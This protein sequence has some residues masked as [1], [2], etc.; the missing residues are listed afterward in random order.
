MKKF[1]KWSGLAILAL[2]AVLA[3]VIAI[4]VAPTIE[5]IQPR[6]TTQYWQMESGY[7]LAYTHVPAAGVERSN[8]PIIFLHGGPGGYIHSSYIERA[9]T[10]AAEG[11]DV[12]LYDQIGSGLSDRLPRPKDYSF[13]GHAR[14]LDEIISRHLSADNA[15]LIGQSYG[16]MLVSYYTAMHPDRVH[17][18]IL[19]S[20]GDI[21]PG[22]FDEAGNW[23]NAELYPVPDGIEFRAPLDRSDEMGISSWP[24][25]AVASIAL[26]MTFDTKLMDDEEADSVL[27]TVATQITSGMVCDPANV[28]PEEGGGGFYSHGHSN[29]FAGVDNW[30]EELQQADVPLLVLQGQCDYIPYAASYEHAAIAPQGRYE[31]IEGAGHIIWWDEP[32]AWTEAVLGFLAEPHPTSD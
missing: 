13:Q 14:D 19:T 7:R 27:N 32:D 21:E 4:P 6:E 2:I 9:Q 22:L 15:I 20:P 5:R 17:R 1:L 29:W 10:L 30:R 23:I 28:L 12:Y 25:R 26:A 18:A 31:F 11:Y 8:P 3:V 24:T 16:G